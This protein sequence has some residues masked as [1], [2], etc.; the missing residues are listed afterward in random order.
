M[1]FVGFGLH[2]LAVIRCEGLIG[3]SVDFSVSEVDDLDV[4][5]YDA[6]FVTCC[7]CRRPWPCLLTR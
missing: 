3:I 2:V 1:G 6:V 5:V 4:A 7:C